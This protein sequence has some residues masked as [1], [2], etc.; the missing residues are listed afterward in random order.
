MRHDRPILLA[1]DLDGVLF[2]SELFL[3]DAYRRS[4]INVNEARPGSFP[5]IPETREILD[6]IGWPVPVILER[7]FPSVD[8]AAIA[9]LHSETLSVISAM[10]AD[11][12]GILYPDVVQTLSDLR[13]GGYTLTI[14]SNGRRRYI[15]TVLSTYSISAFF[16]PI[17]TADETGDKIGVLRTYVERL[18]PRSTIMIGDRASDVEAATALDC[19]FIGCDYGHGHR[20][21]IENAGPVVARFAELPAHIEAMMSA[22]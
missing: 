11:R 9:L 2:S 10:V 12:R 1:F 7:L 19:P 5:R 15:E 14:A 8:Q 4:I 20:D 22:G 18:R 21:E 6:H 16:E 3:G 13:A 17:V